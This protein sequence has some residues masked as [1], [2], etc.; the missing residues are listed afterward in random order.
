MIK[1]IAAITVISLISGCWSQSET[2]AQANLAQSF[3][4]SDGL[5]VSLIP[6]E[7]FRITPENNGFSQVENFSRINISE[8]EIPYA[9][10]TTILTEEYLLKN[11]QQLVDTQEVKINDILS[12]LITLR[13]NISG[14]F[15][16]KRWL[17]FGD[18][19]SSIKV[20]ASYPEG[21]T[22][23]FK[24]KVE[25]SLLTLSVTTEPDKRLY[26]G[27][28]FNLTATA[29]FKIKKRFANSIVLRSSDETN[30]TDFVVISTG[31]TKT[32]IDDIQQLA[33]HFLKNNKRYDEVEIIKNKMIKLDNI[34][35]L[36]TTAYAEHKGQTYWLYQVLSY[37]KERFLLIQTQSTKKNKQ[38]FSEQV[39][40]LLTHF[41]FK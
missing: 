18:K 3:Y 17:I 11:K 39:N 27:L 21:A 4:I 12:T 10:Y 36:A 15:F 26:T 41:K 37:Q 16:E 13:E 30:K 38:Q 7:N 34:P 22:T 32:V 1:S 5:E 28:P 23:Q 35:A 20:E 14:T 33:D 6:P 2:R 8:I 25:Q 19:L 24:K 29:D 40:K 31:R 9:S